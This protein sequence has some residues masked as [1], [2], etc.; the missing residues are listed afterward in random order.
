VWAAGGGGG[1]REIGGGVGRVREDSAD[2]RVA[3]FVPPQ[4]GKEGRERGGEGEGMSLAFLTAG[5]SWG[6]GGIGG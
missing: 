4:R 2:I 1:R 6:I 5:F 3:A